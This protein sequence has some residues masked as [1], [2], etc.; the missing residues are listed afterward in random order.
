MATS[1]INQVV[2]HQMELQQATV[3]LMQEQ[4]SVEVTMNLKA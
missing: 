1:I 3:L 4:A 2:D